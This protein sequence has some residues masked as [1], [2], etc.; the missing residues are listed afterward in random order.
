VDGRPAPL[1]RANLAFQAVPVGPGRHLVRLAWRSDALAPGAL[2]AAAALLGLLA[3]L[4]WRR[5]SAPR[6][7][8]GV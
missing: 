3:A 4:A 7:P 5:R 2:L 8:H 6:F 1:L